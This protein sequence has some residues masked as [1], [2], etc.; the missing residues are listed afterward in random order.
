MWG[1]FFDS[2]NPKSNIAL[3]ETF[4]VSEA[5][6]SREKFYYRIGA[7]SLF[8]TGAK[9]ELKKYGDS[10]RWDLKFSPVGGPFRH[11]PYDIMY[12]GGL[13]KT[14]V[15]SPNFDM[16]I[17][18]KVVVNGRAYECRQEPGQQ[19]HLWGSKHAERWT[20]GHCNVFTEDSSAAF[21]GLSARIKIGSWTTP[22][23]SPLFI[24]WRKKE[25]RMNGL[26]RSLLN[27]SR[28]DLPRW[29]FEAR[30]GHTHFNGEVAARVEDFVGVEYTD[31]DGEK[32]WC[33]NTKVADMTITIQENGEKVGTLT[34]EKCA[35]FEVV[36]RVKDPRIPIRI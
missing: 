11:F 24:R 26:V 33:S 9:G 36:A 34:S 7:S 13:P 31:P 20:W 16:R 10:L 28:T 14:K 27:T 5:Q 35:A 32:L 18:G 15:L 19:T 23:V 30:S 17:S 22:T 2:R 4:P 8:H 1:I 3:K 12:R 21:E 29:T 6:F 25:Y